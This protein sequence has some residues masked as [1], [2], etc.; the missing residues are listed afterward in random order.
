MPVSSVFSQEL[1]GS[2]LADRVGSTWEG[3][4]QSLVYNDEIGRSGI[5]QEMCPDFSPV[6]HT[7]AAT[8]KLP[9]W[10]G[11]KYFAGTLMTW[12][13]IE[14]GV[15]EFSILSIIFSSAGF[16]ISYIRQTGQTVIRLD[17]KPTLLRVLLRV[18]ALS[19][20]MTYLDRQASRYR[21]RM[22]QG[23]NLGEPFPNPK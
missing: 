7:C 18:I 10:A 16:D 1:A 8:A 22:R 19:V 9:T 17:C 12:Y 3:T 11:G 4:G 15:F 20:G 2:E 13:I 21:V 6:Q 23:M 5:G 14:R